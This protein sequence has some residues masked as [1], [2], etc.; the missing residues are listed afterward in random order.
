M[1]FKKELEVLINK[2]SMENGSN[3]PDFIIAEYIIECL[4][5]FEKA[6]SMRSQ[7]YG[8]KDVPGDFKEMADPQEVSGG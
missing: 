1:S 3:T 6:V 5:N 4:I 7:W 2:Y 8:R